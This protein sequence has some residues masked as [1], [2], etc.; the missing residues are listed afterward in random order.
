LEDNLERE[1]RARQDIEKTKR[2]VEGDLKVANETIDE[3]NRQK[4]ETET[5]LK[6]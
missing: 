4:Q 2:K 5:A 1:R 3:L 6:K